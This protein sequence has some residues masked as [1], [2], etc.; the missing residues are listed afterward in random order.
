M[1]SAGRDLSRGVGL[2]EPDLPQ[3]R[4]REEHYQI[5][6]ILLLGLLG[7]ETA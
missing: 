5:I 4:E 2:E 1:R 3:L 7:G 6:P